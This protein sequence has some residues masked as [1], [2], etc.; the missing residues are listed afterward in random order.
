MLEF[1]G[2]GPFTVLRDGRPPPIPAG[3]RR[4]FLALLVLHA[5]QVLSTGRIVDELWNGEP[6]RT[7]VHGLEVHASELRKLLGPGVLSTR[8]PGYVLDVDPDVI[9]ATRFQ[10]LASAA[11]E[12]L[13]R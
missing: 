12:T 3:R 7:A 1:R 5:G 6:P 9:D 8:S 13:A 10:R 4:T 2:L 11:Y